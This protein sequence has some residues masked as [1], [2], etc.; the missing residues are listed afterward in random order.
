MKKKGERKVN[1]AS[2]RPRRSQTQ[3]DDQSVCDLIDPNLCYI[4]FGRYEDDVKEGAGNEWRMC[5]C[6]RWVHEYCIDGV[7]VEASGGERLCPFCVM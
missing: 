5:I 7:V 4:C 2:K 6:E 3:T 1:N